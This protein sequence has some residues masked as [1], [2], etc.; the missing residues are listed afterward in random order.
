M[1]R[2]VLIVLV[3]L[4][5]AFPKPS[6]A[7]VFDP[8]V[9]TLDNGLEVV[10]IEN[11]RAPVVTSMVWYRVGSADEEPGVSGIAH[12]LEHLMFRGTDTLAPGEFSQIVARLGGEE[13]AYTTPDATAYYQSV[14]V[15]HLD[16]IMALEADRMAN[17]KLDDSVVLAE[18][19]VI[20]EER[21]QRIDNDPG[22]RMWEMMKA[23]LFLH[24]PYGTPTIGW[25][26][27]IVKLTPADARAFYDRWYSP[28]N[29]ILV[30]TG[31][32]T[33]DQV[34]ALAEKNFGSIEPGDVPD[35]VRVEE[36]D[37]TAPRRVVLE[38]AD[39]EQPS[40]TRVYLAPSYRTA[41]ENEAYALQVLAEILG[42]GT[43]SRLY[44]DLVVGRGVAAFAGADYSATQYDLGTFTIYAVPVPAG[45]M[46]AVEAAVESAIGTLIDT[47]VTDEE[48]ARAVRRL[49]AAAVKARDSLAG[50]AH[51]VGRALVAGETI[52]DIEAWP[53][54]IGAVTAD[55]VNAAARA[56]FDLNRSVTGLL[57]SK[58][59]S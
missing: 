27:E 12:F 47:G 55:E 33:P 37:Q 59:A 9:F 39:V 46:D 14:A 49:Q 13:N 11:H 24:H 40:W 53:E 51:L 42:E 31:D 32:V 23:A 2:H 38:S 19:D 3:L 56:L 28:N 26:N 45:N 8:T 30:I 58:P 50:P 52:E 48:V 6:D 34:R 20:T 4:F 10:V 17:L 41:T 21:H 7:A 22:S 44:R 54:R 5:A 1:R 25:G 18:R 15:E 43:T 16:T 29:A 57:L 35:R 36:P